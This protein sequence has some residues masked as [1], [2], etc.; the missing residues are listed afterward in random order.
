MDTSVNWTAAREEGIKMYNTSTPEVLKIVKQLQVDLKAYY[1]DHKTK[2]DA[3][4]LRNAILLQDVEEEDK[5]NAIRIIKKVERRDQCYWNFRFHQGTW[6]SAQAINQ[7]QIP[8]SWKTMQEYKE[9]AELKW[10]DP[11]KVDKNDESLWIVI[12]APEEI[13]FFLLKRN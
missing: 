12:T 4:L 5:A 9:D 3:Y 11:K 2:R 7:I 10:E 8:K 6:L 1:R 13:E